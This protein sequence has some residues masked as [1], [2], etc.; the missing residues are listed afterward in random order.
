M[1]T[2]IDYLFCILFL[3]KTIVGSLPQTKHPDD[4]QYKDQNSMKLNDQSIKIDDK[5]MNI[6]YEYMRNQ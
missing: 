6:H 4:L 1:N 3:A 2:I 5:S